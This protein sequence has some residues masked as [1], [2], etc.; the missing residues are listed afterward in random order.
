MSRL[1]HIPNID[2]NIHSALNRLQKSITTLQPDAT[3]IST[4]PTRTYYPP[5]SAP[6]ITVSSKI[7]GEKEWY[8]PDELFNLTIWKESTYLTK[9]RKLSD[10]EYNQ[11][12]WGF[13][14]VNQW[15][16]WDCYLVSSIKNLARCSYFDTLMKTSIKKNK[17]WSFD[18]FMPLWSPYSM[19]LHISP[20][21][22]NLAA[23]KWKTGY[24]LLE[25]WFIKHIILKRNWYTSSL[26]IWKVPNIKLNKELVNRFGQWWSAIRA[27]NDFL[28][29]KNIDTKYLVNN[30]KTYN[31]I[32]NKLNQFNP[33]TWNRIFVSMRR[34][35]NV[36]YKQ[37]T[38][39]VWD[40]KMY[41]HHLYG[42]YEIEKHWNRIEYV[43]LEQPH[44]KEKIRLPIEL[45]RKSFDRMQTIK[46]KKLYN[47][48]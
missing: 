12:F 32:T 47:D 48:L 38:F 3:R 33:R 45:F 26:N 5:E 13:I 37:K 34:P 28:W 6:R 11:L 19:K 22:L 39:F 41:Y 36:S 20:E 16:L 46:L 4:R 17:D 18:L 30:I 24:K 10:K 1:E 27:F 25:L 40:N 35:K 9:H 31:I 44:T 23:I 14:D 2:D 7:V 15:Y 8:A 42:I 21:E 43:T 29:F